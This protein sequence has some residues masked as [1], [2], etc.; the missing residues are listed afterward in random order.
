MAEG[1]IPYSKI[2]NYGEEDLELIGD[3][4]EFFVAV[5]RRVDA[6]YISDS[7]KKPSQDASP[8]DVIETVSK[9]APK[10]DGTHHKRKRKGG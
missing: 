10:P 9:L 6:D 4:L 5:I 2:K 1:Y 3:E 8:K 7:N